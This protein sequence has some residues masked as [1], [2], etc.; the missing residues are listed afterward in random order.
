MKKKNAQNIIDDNNCDLLMIH[1]VLWILLITY[2]SYLM[3]SLYYFMLWRVLL[4]SFYR[5][6][7]LSLWPKNIEPAH[8]SWNWN[9]GRLTSWSMGQATTLFCWHSHR[10]IYVSN[11]VFL[12]I[13]NVFTRLLHYLSILLCLYHRRLKVF[14]PQGCNS[15]LDVMHRSLQLPP[16]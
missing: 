10:V 2:M 1:Y 16:R 3:Q 5:W 14:L 9:S 12:T 7:N 6:R 15:P 11:V 4:L 13:A 8:E